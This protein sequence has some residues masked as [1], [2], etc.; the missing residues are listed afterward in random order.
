MWGPCSWAVSV[1]AGHVSIALGA[2][3]HRL[4][5]RCLG[6]GWCSR[7]GIRAQRARL[8]AHEGPARRREPA[9]AQRIWSS[10][11]WLQASL[12]AGVDWFPCPLR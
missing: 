6:T 4:A 5:L 1:G 11:H 2:W 10:R 12:V 9:L 7:N 3:R 8:E